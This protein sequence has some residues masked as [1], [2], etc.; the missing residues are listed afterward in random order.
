MAQDELQYLVFC[1]ASFLWRWIAFCEHEW[2]CR[3]EVLL[4]VYK[5]RATRDWY[6]FSS[7]FEFRCTKGAASNTGQLAVRQSNGLRNCKIFWIRLEQGCCY[8]Q[9]AG[10]DLGEK[11]NS[12]TIAWEQQNHSICQPK[13]RILFCGKNTFPGLVNWILVPVVEQPIVIPF[14]SLAKFHSFMTARSIRLI[15]QRE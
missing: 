11:Y 6:D 15:R 14:G 7:S 1:I 10:E 5:R 13:I 8:F 9:L 3:V 4:I 12:S 2:W